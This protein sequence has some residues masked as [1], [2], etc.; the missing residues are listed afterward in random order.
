MLR[1]NIAPTGV[2]FTEDRILKYEWKF[3]YPLTR[4][5]GTG[6]TKIHATRL[7]MLVCESG[8]G[9]LDLLVTIEHALFL[10]ELAIRV[11]KKNF[12]NEVTLQVVIS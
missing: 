7:W 8:Y 4:P 10:S 11:L 12:K 2:K 3:D 9:C 5:L 1:A 6:L